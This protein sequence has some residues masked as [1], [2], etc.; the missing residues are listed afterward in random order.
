[1]ETAI[2]ENQNVMRTACP[3]QHEHPLLAT[4]FKVSDKH[5]KEVVYIVSVHCEEDTEKNKL[6]RF[7][8]HNL[9]A[10]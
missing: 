5:Q 4:I 3:D 8:Q 6:A 10:S 9:L 7:T 1:M 2:Y